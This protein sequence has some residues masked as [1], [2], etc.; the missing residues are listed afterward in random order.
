MTPTGSRH[1]SRRNLSND[2]VDASGLEGDHDQSHRWLDLLVRCA[3]HQGDPHEFG[4]SMVHLRMRRE[5]HRSTTSDVL[6]LLREEQGIMLQ[7]FLSG[8]LYT[9]L[10]PFPAPSPSP[11]PAPL[12]THR[13][14]PQNQDHSAM[15]SNPLSHP[16]IHPPTHPP[17]N[18]RP[19]THRSKKR[20]WITP[21][22]DLS[23]S[24]SCCCCAVITRELSV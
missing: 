21:L 13:S 15:Q 6:R 12:P 20:F 8:I 16:S 3:C 11:Y 2:T 4:A 24:R 7:P 22:P 19:P 1:A 18:N 14:I 9:S 17:S 10:P 5:F 23:Q